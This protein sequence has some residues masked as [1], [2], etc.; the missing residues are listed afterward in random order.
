MLDPEVVVS[1]VRQ[2]SA[3]STWRSFTRKRGAIGAFF[4]GASRDP[5]PLLIFTPES[6][7]E[8]TDE[9]RPLAAILFDDLSEISLRATATTMSDSM[10]AWLH[11]WLDLHYLDGRK[12][13]WEPS[14]YKDNLR[15]IQC[16]IEVY[17]IHASRRH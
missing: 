11:V 15:I 8:Y 1:R 17:G 13:K 16:F 3:P 9:N 2:G 14:S 7:I 6:V 12:V 10:H 4:R 5:D